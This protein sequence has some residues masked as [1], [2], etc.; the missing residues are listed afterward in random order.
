[1]SRVEAVSEALATASDEFDIFSNIDR[2]GCQEIIAEMQRKRSFIEWVRNP[3]GPQKPGYW[4][5]VAYLFL[6]SFRVGPLGRLRA[7]GR[8]G[9]WEFLSNPPLEMKF[10]EVVT[11]DTKEVGEH[12]G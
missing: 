11:T 7:A 9:F 1:M 5:R 4:L 10:D 2:K 3:N 12:I 6:Y 8:C